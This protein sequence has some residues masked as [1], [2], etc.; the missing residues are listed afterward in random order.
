MRKILLLF[1]SLPFANAFAVEKND[2][3][4]VEVATYIYKQ[5][6]GNN[7]ALDLYKPKKALAERLPVIIL[8]HG[9][10]WSKGDKDA[11]KTQCI[12]FAEQGIAAVTANYRLV[13]RDATG[14][15]K[16]KAVCIVDAKSAIRWVIAHADKLGIDPDRMILGGGS[17]GGH[18][19]TMATFDQD[20]NDPQDDASIT[21]GPK[22]LVLFNPAY[23]LNGDMQLQPFDKIDRPSPPVILFFGDKD[24]KWLPGGQKFHELLKNLQVHTELWIAP[25]QAHAFFNKEPWN[26]AT[27]IKA[28]EFLAKLGLIDAFSPLITPDAVLIQRP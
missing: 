6:D 15:L 1:L 16:T 27:R 22:G 7:L 11:F 28:A 13:N 4:A 12:F 10:A 19:A 3:A 2:S 9:G 14:I 24:Q 20:L 17:A 21:I 5:I 23:S 8:F 26:S 25:D 18:L